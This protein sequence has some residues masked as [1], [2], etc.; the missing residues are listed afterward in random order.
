MTDNDPAWLDKDY[1]PLL[2]IDPNATFGAWA[3]R[4]ANAR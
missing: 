3:A 2:V 1:N 4:S